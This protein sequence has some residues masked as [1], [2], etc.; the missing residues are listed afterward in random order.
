MEKLLLQQ[1]IQSNLQ[2]KRVERVRRTQQRQ[3]QLEDALR[4]V[5]AAKLRAL[6]TI[7][8]ELEKCRVRLD[9]AGNLSQDL[10]EAHRQELRDALDTLHDRKRRIREK[11]ARTYQRALRILRG[12]PSVQTKDFSEALSSIKRLE[13]DPK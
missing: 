3:E 1:R 10:V 9:Q 4:E 11:S 13:K 8:E 12:N 7:E 6:E 5:T 2:E